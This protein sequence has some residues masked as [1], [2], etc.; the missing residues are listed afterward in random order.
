ME[1]KIRLQRIVSVNTVEYLFIKENDN[2]F[3][4]LII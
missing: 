2:F 1:L 3:H 4:I